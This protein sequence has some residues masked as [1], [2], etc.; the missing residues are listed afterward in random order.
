[1]C[2]D[3]NLYVQLADELINHHKTASLQEAYLRTSISRS[4]Y[5]VFCIARNF[6]ISKGIYMQKTDTHKFVSDQ[7]VDSNN[8]IEKKIG[9]DLNRLRRRRRNADYED[10]ATINLNE[11]N[12]AYSMAL[13]VMKNLTNVGAT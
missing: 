2:F 3:W 7:Y 11:A 9:Q 5:G 10:R 8:R 13:C 4:Y 6:L 12:T 1:M